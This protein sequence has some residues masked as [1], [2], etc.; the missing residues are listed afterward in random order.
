MFQTVKKV[1]YMCHQE[2]ESSLFLTN[3]VNVNPKDLCFVV[4]RLWLLSHVHTVNSL[5]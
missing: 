1:A 4:V 2:N 5:I 3:N